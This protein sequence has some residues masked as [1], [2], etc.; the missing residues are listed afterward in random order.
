MMFHWKYADERSTPQGNVGWIVAQVSD[1]DRA[2]QVANTIDAKSAYDKSRANG[3][4][5]Y[6]TDASASQKT[7]CFWPF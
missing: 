3:F 7:V 6:A 1:P 4:S 5:P 2:V